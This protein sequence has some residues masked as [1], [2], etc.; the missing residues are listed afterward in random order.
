MPSKVI[1]SDYG[2]IGENLD[3]KKNVKVEID[4]VGRIEAVSYEDITTDIRTQ[5]NERKSLVIPGFINSHTH[6]GDSFAKEAG[7]NLDLS[8]VVAPPDGLKHRLLRTTQNSIKELGIKQAS[9]EMLSNGITYFVDFRENGLAGI[10]VLKNSILGIGISCFILG[11][12][13]KVEDLSDVYNAADGLGFSSYKV[14]SGDLKRKLINLKAKN[15]KLFA[16]HDAEK[17]RNDKLFE[18]MINDKLIDVVIHGTQ[19]R[20]KE[21]KEIKDNDISLVLCPRSNGYFG[22][23]IPPINEIIDLEIPISLGTDNVMANSLD[24][25]EEMRYLFIISRVLSKGTSKKALKS[26]DLLKM[27]TTNA[28]RNFGITNDLGSI[29][30]G[31]FANFFTIELNDANYYSHIINTDSVYPLIVQRTKSENIKRTYTG[32]EIVFERK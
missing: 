15:H 24:L 8:N 6:I 20:R 22:V 32:G 9:R 28:A 7:I 5:I 31:K 3:F 26:K 14:I 12:F 30:K 4:G 10:N 17:A 16:S 19:Y 29:S 2:L 23:G 21:L 18:E 27:V 1:S 11:R 13:S 25:F